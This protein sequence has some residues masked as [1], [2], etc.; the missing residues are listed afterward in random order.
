MS[1]YIY[2]RDGR[3]LLS[4]L[5][6]QGMKTNKSSHEVDQDKSKSSCRSYQV[7]I[8]SW[9]DLVGQ[10]LPPLIFCHLPPAITYKCSNHTYYYDNFLSFAN[11][12][13]TTHWLQSL[14][15]FLHTL[16]RLDWKLL[17][18]FVRHSLFN[19]LR[20]L[21]S[22][23][24]YLRINTML[25]FHNTERVLCDIT[26]VPS[27]SDVTCA[28]GYKLNPYRGTCMRFVRKLLS[29]FDAKAECERSGEYLAS[30]DTVESAAW[31]RNQQLTAGNVIRT[32]R[33]AGNLRTPEH[34]GFELSIPECM[35]CWLWRNSNQY[36]Y[37]ST[38]RTYN[39]HQQ[40]VFFAH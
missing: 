36:N 18:D 34:S 31:Y 22:C 30:F 13:H 40:A 11:P 35:L 39:F 10:F 33:R 12:H 1:L 6:S 9:L 17:C 27:L 3:K 2:P 24:T 7:I 32:E 4:V 20:K 21:P 28:A 16:F 15:I 5:S 14:I 26:A 8:K 25:S 38:Q 19:Q 29:W 23:E 37:F